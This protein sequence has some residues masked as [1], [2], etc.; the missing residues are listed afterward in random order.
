MLWFDCGW[1]MKLYLSDN[2][3]CLPLQLVLSSV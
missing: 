3:L 2:E 1:I